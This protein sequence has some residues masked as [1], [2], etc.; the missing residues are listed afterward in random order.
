ML[1]GFDPRKL[2]SAE[3]TAEILLSLFWQMN[4]PQHGEGHPFKNDGVYR[5][6]KMNFTEVL[7]SDFISDSSVQQQE[8]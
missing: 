4:A 6:L 5:N 8:R 7:N 3:Y 2:G 1:S